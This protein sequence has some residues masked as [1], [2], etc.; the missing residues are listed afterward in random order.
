MAYA[1]QILTVK[2]EG[3]EKK[4]KFQMEKIGK[5][6]A[7]IDRLNSQ[8]DLVTL[9]VEKDLGVFQHETKNN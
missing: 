2:N 1:N 9:D 6:E 3:L 5:L 8:L 4:N 7:E